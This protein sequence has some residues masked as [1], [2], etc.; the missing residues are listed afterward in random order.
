MSLRAGPPMPESWKDSWMMKYNSDKPH[1]CPNCHSVTVTFKLPVAQTITW[2]ERLSW[3]VD[4]FVSDHFRYPHPIRK[5][6]M[7]IAPARATR[8]LTFASVTC[9][10][11]GAEFTRWPWLPVFKHRGV[12]CTTHRDTDA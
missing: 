2:Q 8:A 7:S 9:C 10:Q 11:C 6:W 5:V 1:R 4:D 3:R 12:I